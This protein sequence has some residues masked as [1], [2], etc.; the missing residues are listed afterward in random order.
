MVVSLVLQN[1]FSCFHCAHIKKCY[2]SIG[3]HNE[4][5]RMLKQVSKIQGN[6]VDKKF[7]YYQ[8]SKNRQT[9]QEDSVWELK[10]QQSYYF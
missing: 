2:V 4:D 8:N 5:M 9:W 10:I 7:T 1:S 3:G 6:K